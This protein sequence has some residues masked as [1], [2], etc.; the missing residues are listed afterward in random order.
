MSRTQQLNLLK[1]QHKLALGTVWR[2]ARRKLAFCQTWNGAQRV[3]NE[4]HANV[5]KVN[6]DSTGRYWNFLKEGK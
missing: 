2:A 3:L 4:Y 6:F 1:R 5:A